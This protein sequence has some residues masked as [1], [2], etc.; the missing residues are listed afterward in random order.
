MELL[1]TERPD[2]ARSKD[3][4]SIFLHGDPVLS[5]RSIQLLKERRR[6]DGRD[7]QS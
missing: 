6:E 1:K 5:R 3:A 4:G 2:L 7:K